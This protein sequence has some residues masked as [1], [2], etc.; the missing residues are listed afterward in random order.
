MK[1]RQGDRYKEIENKNNL[2]IS[3]NLLTAINKKKVIEID[4]FIEK[5]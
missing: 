4:N 2:G 1:C 3:N 5:L